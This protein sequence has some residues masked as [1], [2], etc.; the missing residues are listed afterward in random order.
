MMGGG[1]REEGGGIGRSAQ[2]CGPPRDSLI[3]GL[4]GA[5]K[6]TRPDAR[7]SAYEPMMGRVCGVTQRTAREKRRLFWERVVVGRVTQG[8]SV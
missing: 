7:D 3:Q 5:S 4:L 8:Y 1:R 6:V 2:V